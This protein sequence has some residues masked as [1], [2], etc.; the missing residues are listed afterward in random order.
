MECLARDFDLFDLIFCG[1]DLRS[2]ARCGSI[3][4]SMMRRSAIQPGSHLAGEIPLK[5]YDDGDS[6]LRLH[7]SMADL[8]PA[9]SR[10][11]KI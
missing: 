3:I 10:N 6:W 9:V 2:R 1:D 7:I 4:D 8:A 11:L 5:F